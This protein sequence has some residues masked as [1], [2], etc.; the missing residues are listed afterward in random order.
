MRMLAKKP[1]DR[2]PDLAAVI[3]AFDAHPL[4]SLGPVRAEMSALAAA[5]EAEAQPRGDR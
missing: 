2:F 5:S 3:E 4:S 1:E